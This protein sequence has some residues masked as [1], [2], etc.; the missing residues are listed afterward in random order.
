PPFWR[1]LS[2]VRAPVPVA[3]LA[4]TV[5]RAPVLATAL[6]TTVVDAFVPATLPATLLA[7]ETTLGAKAIVLGTVPVDAAAPGGMAKAMAPRHAS[8][9]TTT[10]MGT[11]PVHPALLVAPMMVT[12]TALAP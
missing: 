4:T 10:E 7:D 3:V 1:R 6:A 9:P 12:A 8:A 5:V 2:S 11:A